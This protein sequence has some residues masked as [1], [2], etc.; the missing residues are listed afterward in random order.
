MEITLVMGKSPFLPKKS[1]KAKTR[2][3]LFSAHRDTEFLC[4]A[5]KTRYQLRRRFR[6]L[7]SLLNPSELA[8]QTESRFLHALHFLS[9]IRVPSDFDL[10]PLMTALQSERRPGKSSPGID[11]PILC[12]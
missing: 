9:V 10:V 11:C 7:Y 8:F 6:V 12:R 3:R 1:E 2:F 5:A 4:P